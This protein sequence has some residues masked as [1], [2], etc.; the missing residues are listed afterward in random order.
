MCR[1]I[2]C[3]SSCFLNQRCFHTTIFVQWFRLS[4][5]LDFPKYHYAK[6]RREFVPLSTHIPQARKRR[7]CLFCMIKRYQVRSISTVKRYFSSQQ[8]SVPGYS[9]IGKSSSL[10]VGSILS[11]FLYL[12]LPLGSIYLRRIRTAI[13]VER[14]QK[15]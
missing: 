3:F 10:T 15:S 7:M 11:F 4:P 1:P 6:R 2:Q 14:G 13:P 12:L 9:R 8:R 5:K